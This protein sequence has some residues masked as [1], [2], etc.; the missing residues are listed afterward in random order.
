MQIF[1]YSD[2]SGVFDQV[3]GDYFIFGGLIFLSKT[4]RD[5]AQRKY[6]HAENVI[7]KICNYDAG[8]EIKASILELHHK[9]KLYRSLNE[10]YKF[11]V[12]IDLKLINNHIFENKK[13]KQR[14]LDYAYK[15][16]VKR[17]LESL[18]AVGIIDPSKVDQIHFYVDE[19]STATDGKYELKE[20][21]ER[22]FK[23]GTFNYN[24]QKFFPP[25]LPSLRNIDLHFIDSKTTDLVRAADIV[26]NRV[27]Y[28]KRNQQ[29]D[30]LNKNNM[31]VFYLP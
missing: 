8:I 19:H 11:A 2:E 3:H 6:K 7:R 5:D 29:L 17:K 16:A 4:A 10:C 1:V 24:Y 14:Y 22:E 28:C 23:I 20:A 21:I 27:Y 26:A 18:I 9:A 25:I 12:I 31:S 15:I 30:N 13:S